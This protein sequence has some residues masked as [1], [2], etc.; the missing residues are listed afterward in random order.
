MTDR[1][2]FAAADAKAMARE[3]GRELSD[4]QAEALAVY[5]GKLLAWNRRMNLVGKADAASVMA[6]LAA[7]CWHLADFLDEV[8]LPDDPLTLDL[9]AGA[10]IPGVVLRIFWDRGRYVMV[11]PRRKR[12][13][14]VRTVLAMLDLRST[15]IREARIEDLEEEL[16]RADLVLGRAFQPWREF[17][18]TAARLTGP[19]GRALVFANESGPEGGIPDGWALERVHAYEV[20]GR[21]RYFW[22]FTPA[23]ISR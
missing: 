4:G 8:A 16:G 5:V 15:E 3:L 10:G 19:G 2:G 13:V 22:F 7:D 11:E 1:T 9:G 23:S 21:T 14:F 17:L 6:E 12:A 18:G 20:A